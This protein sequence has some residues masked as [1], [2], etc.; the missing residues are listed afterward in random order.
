MK[1]FMT[2]ANSSAMTSPLWPPT[3]PPTAPRS[4]VMAAISAKTFT[5]FISYSDKGLRAP[6]HGGRESRD[7]GKLIKQLPCQ[8]VS[9]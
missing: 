4:A 8:F 9:G 7:T 2:P 1:T 6:C 5:L 3:A